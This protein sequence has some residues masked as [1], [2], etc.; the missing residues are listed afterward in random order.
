VFFFKALA[1]MVAAD[2]FDRHMRDQQHRRWQQDDRVT[3]AAEAREAL[4]TGPWHGEGTA[5]MDRSAPER[6]C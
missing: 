4:S 6:P 3:K 2:A 5:S 1:A